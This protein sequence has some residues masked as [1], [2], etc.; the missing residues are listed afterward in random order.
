MGISSRF[1]FLCLLRCVTSAGVASQPY[2]FR[3]GWW[4]ITPIGFP[5][6]DFS[7]LMLLSSSPELFAGLHVLLRL[8]MPRHPPAALNNLIKLLIRHSWP[9]LGFPSRGLKTFYNCSWSN[10]PQAPFYFSEICIFTT[11][12][13]SL[14]LT[15]FGGEFLRILIFWPDSNESGLTYL[16]QTVKITLSCLDKRRETMWQVIKLA[17]PMESTWVSFP[18]VLKRRWSSPT[19][20]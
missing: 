19:F 2:E 3:L 1:L 11:L 15:S 10:S 6:S 17:Q 12:K 13:M 20:R 4:D 8:L 9:R 18:I 16:I 5:H 14:K 7:G